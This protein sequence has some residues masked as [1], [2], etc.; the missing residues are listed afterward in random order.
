MARLK[1]QDFGP[2]KKCDIDVDKTDFT[3]L[4]G[5]QASGKSTIVKC[6]YFFRAAKELL[7]ETLRKYSMYGDSLFG[8]GRCKD[9]TGLFRTTLRER[10]LDLFGSTQSMDRTMKITYKYTET[11]YIELFVEDREFDDTGRRI[12]N[13]LN[14]RFGEPIYNFLRRE[15][16]SSISMPEIEPL[17][18][19]FEN[20]TNDHYVP[21]F[22][23]A[24]RCLMSLLTSQLNYFFFSLDDYQKRAMD[25]CTL[26]FIEYISKLKDI[27][28][29]GLNSLTELYDHRD[30]DLIIRLGLVKSR[31]HSILGGEY[32][33]VNGEERLFIDGNR[34]I[35]INYTSSGQQ[36][37]LWIL[38][39]LYYIMASSSKAFV[40]IEEPESHLYPDAQ[41]AIMEI[42]AIAANSGCKV[43]TTTHSPY[44][45]GALN[46]MKYAAHLAANTAAADRVYDV[47]GRDMCL[48]SL[49]AYYVKDGRIE[50][51]LEKTEEELI[52]NT[53]I[54]GASVTINDDYDKLYY[55][56]VDEG[57]SEDDTDAV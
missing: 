29:S 15:I 57:E 28:S 16:G 55:L 1:I 34:F 8:D 45:L 10:F 41:K 42:I 24:G 12:N 21:F 51:C 32:K 4:T 35:K 17:Y 46:N 39:L 44:V 18:K 9:F 48:D 30:K 11:C 2:I 50:S 6:I 23:P 3:V 13:Y 36:E 14:I 54:D 53:I 40:V 22:I 27:M 52:D 5:K 37:T 31:I 47:I 26:K 25:F 19:E 49:S 56:S 38:N 43:I 7:Q 33:I 20:I